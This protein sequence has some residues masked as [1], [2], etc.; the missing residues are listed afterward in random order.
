MRLRALSRLTVVTTSISALAVAG[1]PVA[2][3]QSAPGSFT[4]SNITDFHGRWQYDER[5]E[6]PGALNL[7]C[8]VDK[9]EEAA[10]ADNFVFTSSGDNIGASPYAAMILDDEPTIE[11][12]NQMGLDISALGNH[13]F[14]RGAQ[15]L[16]KR[17]APAAKWTYLAAGVE[18]LD[19]TDIKDYEIRE[20]GGVKVAFIGAVTQDMPNLVS[21]S[22]IEG[23]TWA[24]PAEAINKTA[25][26]LTSSGKADAVV[27]LVHEGHIP[28]EAWS[29]NV[30]VVFMGHSHEFV[31]PS[32]SSPLILQTGSYSKG[33]ANVTFSF[34]KASKKLTAEKVELL[35]TEDLMACDTQ[36][37][38]EERYPEIAATINAALEAAEKEG[39]Q[40]LGEL[41]ESIYRGAGTSGA[42]GSNRGVES[43]VNNLLAEAAKWGVTNNSSV[44]ADI[45]VMN[46]GGVRA[47]LSKGTVTFKD[48]FDVQPFGNE[49]T[50]TTLKGADF[51][52]A[53]EQQWKE[54]GAR[55][56]VLS[57]GVSDNVSYTYDETRPL[58]DRI[59][60]VLVD[61]E[62][63]DPAR[64]YVVAGSTFLLGGGDSFTA[65][66]KGTELA[67]FGFLD[68]QA[69]TE[70][71]TAYLKEGSVAGP[72]T[73]QSNVAV[74]L[75]EPLKAGEN[76]TIELSSLIYS[77]GETAKQVTVEIGSEKAT[78][79]ID[80]SYIPDGVGEAG[81]ASVTLKVPADSKREERLRITTDAG[82][83][84]WLP[85]TVDGAKPQNPSPEP[86][87]GAENSSSSSLSPAQAIL[88]ALVS[89][90]GFGS[91]V[92]FLAPQMEKLLGELARFR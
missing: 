31:D 44:K 22:G 23:I 32:E 8:A 77:L 12:L 14:D 87:P 86:S 71:L 52:E 9:A 90:I 81:K 59:T 67:N 16:V 62:P 33:L 38:L 11:V 48:A 28:A 74:H 53:L 60:S 3:A 15:D 91:L 70:Y 35:K 79:D 21:P 42:P 1:L 88:V 57:L 17:V 85:V 45:G 51:K 34:D 63:L 19:K 72:R 2:T 56:A 76:T 84:V 68:I 58:G 13:E 47:D 24:N 80:T 55:H 65:L 78:A 82:T 54:P 46:A 37:N 20:L 29:N 92:A 41:N 69:W 6:V 39:Q 18:S 89:L 40:V 4:I 26:E 30:D 7:R 66:T 49:L 61:G 36:Q 43:Q 50:Y 10:G 64:D 73:G 75:N 5:N 27:A 25:D 83:D